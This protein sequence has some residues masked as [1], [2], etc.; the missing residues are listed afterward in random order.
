MSNSS[1]AC[2]YWALKGLEASLC[3]TPPWPMRMFKANTVD[4]PVLIFI[5]TKHMH[6]GKKQRST[7]HL[8]EHVQALQALHTRYSALQRDLET[9]L[10]R[11]L[12]EPFD[13]ADSAALLKQRALIKLAVDVDL[14]GL[15][16]TAQMLQAVIA[17]LVRATH[18]LVFTACILG[19]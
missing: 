9:S 19:D 5:W 2:G 14:H 8:L 4:F 11:A 17:Q 10:Q 13:A 15:L 16:P 3:F 1:T 12:D 7:F 18:S 6:I